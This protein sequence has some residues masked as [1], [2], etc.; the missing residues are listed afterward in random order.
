LIYMRLRWKQRNIC[1]DGTTY[2]LYIND[3]DEDME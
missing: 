1:R 2:T 3:V